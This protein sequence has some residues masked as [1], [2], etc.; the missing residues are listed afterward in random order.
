MKNGATHSGEFTDPPEPT[1]DAREKELTVADVAKGE[2][3]KLWFA[4]GE[5]K[6]E[7]ASASPSS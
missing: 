4:L 3:A 6:K 1:E 5:I 7:K 2:W